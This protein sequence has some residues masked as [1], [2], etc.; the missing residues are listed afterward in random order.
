MKI[1][2]ALCLTLF[3]HSFAFSQKQDSI[4]VSQPLSATAN[5][6]FTNNGV[7]LFPNLSLGRPAVIATLSVGK[8]G[9]YFEPELRWGLNGK[10]WSYIYWLRYKYRK[11]EKFGI[12]VG[13]H[14][15]YIVKETEVQINGVNDK[16]YVAQRYAAVELA[17]TYYFSKKFSLGVYALQATR[18]DNNGIKKSQ[19]Y[20]LMPRFPSIGLSKSYYLSFYPQIFYLS[21]DTDSGTYFNETLILSKK[22]FPISLSS[23]FTTKIKSEIAG[24]KIVWNVG[25]NIKL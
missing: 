25:L 19:F 16:R 21:L 23:V 18:L 17:P 4:K 24:D 6:Q 22:N 8:K 13:A 14:P 11:S 3:L 20:S 10:P 7:S 15:S 12:T 5:V 2:L 1:K 9:V